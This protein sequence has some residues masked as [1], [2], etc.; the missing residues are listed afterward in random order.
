MD[1]KPSDANAIDLQRVDPALLRKLFS[2][3]DA[4]RDA[5]LTLPE[6]VDYRSGIPYGPD[7]AWHTLDICWPKGAA[8][9]LPVIVSVHGGGYVYGS[10]EVYRFYAADLARRGFAVVNFNYRLAPDHVFPAPLEDLN[11]VM[12]WLKANA[13]AYPVDLDNVFLVGD[14][15]GAQLASQYAV[16]CTNP[17]YAAVMGLTPPLPKLRA[18]GLNCGM[19][20]PAERAAT[21]GLMVAYYT[22]EPAQFGEK[23]HPLDYLD[24][25]YPPTYLLTA[26]GDFLRE[27]CEPMAKLLTERGVE[28]AWKCYGDKS[29]GHV[30]HLD[31]RLPLGREANDDETAFFKQHMH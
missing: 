31:I 18:I 17:R 16:V 6:D 2:E 10:A 23:L 11:A 9:P 13:D 28:N 4:R 8:G 30:F 3:A 7:P 19:Y 15:A 25:A 20:D 21:G 12:A 27:H 14:S 29:V 1:N 5:G 24:A 22:D 26:G